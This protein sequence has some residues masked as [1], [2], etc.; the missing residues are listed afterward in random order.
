M[1]QKKKQLCKFGGRRN[2]KNNRKKWIA[3]ATALAAI[4]VLVGTF[5]WF[6]SN[7]RTVNKFEGGVGGNDVEIVEDFTPPTDWQPGQEVKKEVGILNS[8]LYNSFV[9]VSL[10][11][12]LQKLK[13]VTGGEFGKLSSD[14]ANITGKSKEEIYVY[15]YNGTLEGFSPVTN[16]SYTNTSGDVVQGEPKFT[17]PKQDEDPNDYAG[18][19]TLK[20]FSKN[21]QYTAY[22]YDAE[23][24]L[25]YYAK[26]DSYKKLDNGTVSLQTTPQYEFITL[27]YA[28]ATTSNWTIDK[29]TVSPDQDGNATV[30]SATDGGKQ[31]KINFVN[32]ASTPTQGKWYYNSAGGRFYYVGKLA[33]QDTTPLLINSVTLDDGADNSY[34]KVKYDLTVNADSIQAIEGAAGSNQWVGTTNDTLKNALESVADKKVTTPSN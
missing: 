6:T 17:I 21:N 11:G 19:Y 27:D 32:L 9:R 12:T 3:A 26:V 33:P 25:K 28:T 34:T 4:G 23:K 5:A 10:E 16:L 13:P 22:W 29:P 7:D 31:I 18:T 1:S 24:D 14:P 8:G 20:V 15:P 2:E 30:V